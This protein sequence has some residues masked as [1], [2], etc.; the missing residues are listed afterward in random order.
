MSA[1]RF[2]SLL[3]TALPLAAVLV[4]AG[5]K[6]DE[7][8]VNNAPGPATAADF[9]GVTI[10]INPTFSFLSNGQVTY[11]NTA[12]GGA[13]PAASTLINGT[14][15]YTPSTDYLTGN[16]AITLPTTGQTLQLNLQ[17]FTT[18]GGRVTSFNA[19]YNGQNYNATVKNGTLTSST[20][21]GGTGGA[22][23]GSGSGTGTGGS[24]SGSGSGSGT[25]TGGGT[26]IPTPVGANEALAPDIPTTMQGTYNLTFTYVQTGSPIAEGTTKTFVIGAKSLAF[27]NKTLTGPVHR[28]GNK[29]E[30]IFKDGD[31]EYAAS[32]RNDNTLNEINVGKTGGTPWYGQYRS[33]GGS[34]NTGGSGGN[35]GGG[36]QTGGGL[37]AGTTFTRTVNNVIIAP[38]GTQVP[39]GTPSFAKGDKVTFTVNASGEIT[40]SNLTIPFSADGG[41]AYSYVGVGATGNSDTVLVHKN[42]TTGSPGAVAIQLVRAVLSPIPSV[43]MIDYTLE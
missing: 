9:A 1:P 12:T 26:T 5:C 2:L 35:S 7:A 23:T 14:Y 34:G 24:G 21:P 17:S 32:I 25:G 28:N 15:T 37:A 19:T 38:I 41:T 39:A 42:L 40:F 29:F 22:G 13:F 10:E 3:R 8:P 16:L 43:Q 20:L 11:V 33:L 31:L 4:F 36:T 18:Q 27:D 30:W 6:N